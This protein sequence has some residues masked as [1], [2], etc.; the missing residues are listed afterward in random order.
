[1]LNS[2]NGQQINIKD[3]ET[4]V[5]GFTCRVCIKIQLSVGFISAASGSIHEL[6]AGNGSSML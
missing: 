6:A 2:S 3:L 4:N 1:M 5:I